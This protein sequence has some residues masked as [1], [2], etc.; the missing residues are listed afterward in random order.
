MINYV[1]G[2]MFSKDRKNIALIK[3]LK[4]E[5]QKGKWN[6]IGG[7]IEK[8]ETPHHAIVREFEEETGIKTEITDWQLTV[9]LVVDDKA[10]VFFLRCFSDDAFKVVSKELEETGIF[11]VDCLPKNTIPNLKWLVPLNADETVNFP[12]TI[13]DSI[14]KFEKH[15]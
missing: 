12:I 8:G 13:K 7:K 9:G 1:A 15:D 4:P 11:R 14:G 3:K 6:A 5:W 10:F 2:F